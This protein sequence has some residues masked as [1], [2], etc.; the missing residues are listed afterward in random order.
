MMQKYKQAAKVLLESI[1]SLKK[2]EK[3]P[4][5]KFFQ[6]VSKFKEERVNK[7]FVDLCCS[8]PDYT[9]VNSI[10]LQKGPASKNQLQVLETYFTLLYEKL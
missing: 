4:I 5:M 2:S 1:K 10:A 7:Q 8:L 3:M 9:R 6:T